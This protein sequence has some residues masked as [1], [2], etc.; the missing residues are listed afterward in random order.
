MSPLLIAVGLALAALV[1]V[2]AVRYLAGTAPRRV[3]RVWANG[4]AERN[5][6]QELT[7][8]S[9]AEPL[10]RVFDDVLRPEHDIDVT[11]YAESSYLIESV[12]FRQRVPDRLEAAIYPPLL[13]AA[14]ALGQWSRR[15]ANGR[16]HRYLAY[17]FIGLLAAL[18]VV[19]VTT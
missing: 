19:A 13:A 5:P 1:V 16:V 6:R 8:T 2:G 10:T 17:G 11:P 7:A 3:V 12:T 14:E 15:M 4:G 9:F 18:V